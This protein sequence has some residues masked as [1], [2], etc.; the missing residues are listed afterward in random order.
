MSF[1]LIYITINMKTMKFYLKKVKTLSFFIFLFSLNCSFGQ[2]ITLNSLPSTGGT[3]TGAGT[4]TPGQTVSLQATPNSGFYFLNWTE[5]GTV[6]SNKENYAFVASVNQN[7]T[8]NFSEG[9]LTDCYEGFSFFSGLNTS[10]QIDKEGYLYHDGIHYLVWSNG[11]YNGGFTQY[12]SFDG[13]IRLSTSS[14]GKTWTTQNIL[15]TPYGSI[16]HVLTIDE[17]GFLHLAYNE[18]TNGS[19]YGLSQATLV[20]ANNVSGSWVKQDLNLGTGNGNSYNY[21]RP[22]KLLFGD[23]QKLRMYF[24][25]T[26]WWAYGGPLYI[27]VRDAGTWGA[28]I[29]ISTVNDGGAD[30]Q[31]NLWTV[32]RNESGVIKVYLSAGWNCG[33]VSCTPGYYNVIKE[34]TEGSAYSYSQTNT[35]TG[36]RWYHE[37]DLNDEL[38]IA[39]DGKTYSFNG[40][41]IGVL[42]GTEYMNASTW[43]DQNSEYI[44]TH[45]SLK[46]RIIDTN[47]QDVLVGV[48]KNIIP[49]NGFQIIV[50]YSL[51]PRQVYTL[52]KVDLTI[53]DTIYGDT[54]VCENSIHSFTT[55]FD[56]EA[57][58]YNW[59][60]P[61]GAV[62]LSGQGT[63]SISVNFG[64]TSGPISVSKSNSC[65]LSEEFFIDVFVQTTPSTPI[66][67]ITNDCGFSQVETDATGSLLWSTGETNNSITVNSNSTL[68]L[69]QT[70]NGCIS[71]I[72]SATPEPILIPNPPILNVTNL[73][74]SSTLNAIGSGSITWSTNDIT[75][76]ISVN[77][78]GYYLATQTENGCIS[79]VDSIFAA[80]L[81]IPSVTFSPLSDVCINTPDFN[82]VGA[83]PVGG[84]FSG[85]GVL[86]SQFSPSTSG[87]GTFDIEYI[88]TDAN[89][90]SNS[91]IQ[92][93]TVGCASLNSENLELMIYPNPSNGKFQINHSLPIKQI[94]VY[95]SYGKNVLQLMAVKSEQETEIDLSSFSEG[96]YSLSIEMENAI[97]HKQIIIQH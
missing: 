88:F 13:N 55:P 35:M 97:V 95:D 26:G 72:S 7:I 2:V 31:N 82:L 9:T 18:G 15:T 94:V 93:I 40:N 17:N 16:N 20:Y 32:T 12:S 38:S 30:S 29:A 86:G 75:P 25:T 24:T 92:S 19:Y 22:W 28:P 87:F 89:S 79:D 34:F 49:A 80:P 39:S 64:N 74:G 48:N 85:I 59:T 33:G 96:I 50:D 36:K 27:R 42:S 54:L 53:P 91:A 63:D 6:L 71:S 81:I 57:S 58:T 66:I 60:V 73:C 78:T 51:N 14:D 90:C 10:P 47:F 11:T 44:V 70:I 65:S 23:D 45:T 4:Y 61:S 37:N 83:L 52:H 46:N 67:T 21:T 56:F 5:N 1:A 3:T 62:I 68:T 69:T 77:S 41:V 76:S 43:I 8:A 84:T